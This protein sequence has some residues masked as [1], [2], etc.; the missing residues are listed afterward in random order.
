MMNLSASQ[1]RWYT[2]RPVAS[3]VAIL[4]LLGW[5]G[6]LLYFA[7]RHRLGLFCALGMYPADNRFT[8]FYDYTITFAH[9]HTAAFFRATT[10]YSRFAYPPLFAPVYDALY[11]AP[12]RF[13]VYVLLSLAVW[14]VLLAW[15]ARLLQQNDTIGRK[16]PLVLAAISFL[17]PVTFLM[18][19]G[20]LELFVWAA[21]AAGVYLFSRDR[22]EMSATAFGCAAALKLYPVLLFG[23]LLRAKRPLR[24]IL[25]A[26]LTAVSLS[27]VATWFSGPSFHIAAVGF[28][29]NVSGFQQTYGTGVRLSAMRFDHSLFSIVKVLCLRHG[30]VPN[31]FSSLYYGTGAVLFGGLYFLRVRRLTWQNELLYLTVCTLL[32]P[33]VSYEYTLVHLYVPAFITAAVLG[34]SMVQATFPGALAFMGLLALLLPIDLFPSEG[35]LG[36]GQWQ[37]VLLFLVAALCCF[38]MFRLSLEE[39]DSR[40]VRMESERQ[41]PRA[42]LSK[43]VSLG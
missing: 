2:R 3:A 32:L 14:S 7:Q 23:L 16:W 4:S 15:G 5:T 18:E 36:A 12:H 43:R 31:R 42:T 28:I 37:S 21:T 13:S 26:L 20:N 34:R 38:P 33:P 10:G 25:T 35:L 17:Y 27:I 22:P 30:L 39:A 11:S 40:T 6:W 8:D 1:A 29:R 9:Y 24:A 19:R 41:S